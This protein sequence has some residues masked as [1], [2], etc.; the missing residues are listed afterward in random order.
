MVGLDPFAVRRRF[1]IDD[2]LAFVTGARNFVQI[3]RM[4]GVGGPSVA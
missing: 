2:L 4:A 1:Q 3:S